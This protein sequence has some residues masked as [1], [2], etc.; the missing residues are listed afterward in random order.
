MGAQ[1]GG[2]PPRI[3]ATYGAGV[4]GS[5]QYAISP[6]GRSVTYLDGNTWRLAGASGNR[7]LATLPAVPGRGVNPDEDDSFL[8]LLTD[9]PYI[10]PFPTFHLGGTA[11]TP[12][13]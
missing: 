5:G 8:G 7:V 12:P 9:R 2:G 1:L 4:I 6:D 13:D 10:A 3:L 11:V